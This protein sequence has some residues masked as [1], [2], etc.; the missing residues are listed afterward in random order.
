[1]I[2][3]S[4]IAAPMAHALLDR[5]RPVILSLESGTSTLSDVADTTRRLESLGVTVAGI[6]LTRP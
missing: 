1:M 3:V 4:G 2:A 6:V 5:D